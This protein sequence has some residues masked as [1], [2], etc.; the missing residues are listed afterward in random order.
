MNSLAISSYSAKMSTCEIFENILIEESIE[1][2]FDLA[3]FDEDIILLDR[4]GVLKTCRFNFQICHKDFSVKKAYEFKLNNAP[5]N[6]IVFHEFHREDSK[7]KVKLWQPYSGG[8]L[9]L[10][11]LVREQQLKLIKTRLGAF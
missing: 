5:I 4:E 9:S 8:T 2:H 11:Y 6:L 1:T 7:V 3:D 10:T